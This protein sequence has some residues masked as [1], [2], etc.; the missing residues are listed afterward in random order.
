MKDEKIILE[1]YKEAKVKK[2]INKT[3]DKLSEKTKEIIGKR[4]EMILKSNKTI[5]ERIETTELRKTVAKLIKQDIK[6][7]NEKMTREILDKS[8]SIKKVKKSLCTG[9]YLMNSLINK[10]GTRE[11]R[12]DEMVQIATDFYKCLYESDLR[13]EDEELDV[14]LNKRSNNDANPPF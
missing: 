13:G 6:E 11:F 1:L 9:Q 8:W 4:N 10:D 5:T 2:E 14:D 7:Y 3:E 12:R